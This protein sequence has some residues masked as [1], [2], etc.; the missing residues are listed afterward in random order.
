MFDDMLRD[1]LVNDIRQLSIQRWLLVEPILMLKP[2][3][4]LVLAKY[5]AEKDTKDIQY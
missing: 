4:E 3:L 5:L 1:R 2:I